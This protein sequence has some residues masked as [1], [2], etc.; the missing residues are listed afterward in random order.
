MNNAILD[1][2]KSRWSIRKFTVEP[3]KRAD[4]EQIVETGLYAATGKGGQSSIIVGT[5][6]C[7]TLKPISSMRASRQNFRCR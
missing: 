1:A 7:D 2:I 6:F 4:H 5:G 3:P